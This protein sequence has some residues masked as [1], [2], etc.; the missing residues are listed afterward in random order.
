MS[1]QVFDPDEWLEDAKDMPLSQKLEEYGQSPYSRVTFTAPEWDEMHA[2]AQD[3]ETELTNMGANES[4]LENIGKLLYALLDRA[5]RF[6]GYEGGPLAEPVVGQALGMWDK[7]H[8]GDTV[9]ED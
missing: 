7:L 6:E 3:M 5:A 2:Q 1:E 9:D 8:E 4:A